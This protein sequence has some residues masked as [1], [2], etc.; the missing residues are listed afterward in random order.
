ML[1]LAR[2]FSYNWHWKASE[3]ETAS[4]LDDISVSSVSDS[5]LTDCEIIR[6]VEDAAA[7]AKPD[8]VV[9]TEPAAD[10]A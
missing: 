10:D 6:E 4:L 2:F 7:A 3:S 9:K 8:E 1:K 5:E